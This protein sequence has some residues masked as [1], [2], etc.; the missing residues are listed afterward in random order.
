[1]HV[2]EDHVLKTKNKRKELIVMSTYSIQDIIYSTDRHKMYTLMCSE[3]EL[4]TIFHGYMQRR[5]TPL[6]LVKSWLHLLTVLMISAISMLTY[7]LR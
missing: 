5:F 3:D 2:A 4:G 7:S 1:M 6:M